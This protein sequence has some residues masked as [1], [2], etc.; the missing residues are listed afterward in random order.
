MK[1]PLISAQ[2]G[3]GYHELEIVPGVGEVWTAQE[4]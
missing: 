3:T 1:H 2:T 4:A